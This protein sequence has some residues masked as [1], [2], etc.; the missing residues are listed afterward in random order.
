EVTAWTLHHDRIF[1]VSNTG[2]AFALDTETGE[3][4]WI[5]QVGK[6]GYRAF[7]PGA[8]SK[9][10]AI[11]SG[12]KI[13]VLDRD[14]G[15]ILFS[16][17]LGS[18]PGAGPA[19]TEDY[20]FV[21]LMT[22]RVEGYR[23]D[24]PKAQPWYYN[25]R[26]RAF[27]RPVTTGGVVSWPTNAGLLYVSSATDP[28]LLYRIQTNDEIIAPP[29]ELDGNL[30]IASLDGYLY[31]IDGLTGNE[32]WRFAAG[33]P[34]ESQPAVVGDMAFVSSIE[35]AIHAIETSTGNELWDIPGASQFVSE[36]K[37]RVYAA[38]PMGNLL[39]LDM[40][41]G[42]TLGTL[43]T[44]EG[45]YPL[46]NDQTDRIFLVNKHGLVQCLHEIGVSQPIEHR[47]MKTAAPK[48]KDEG[49]EDIFGV[50]EDAADDEPAEGGGLFD[51]AVEEP[52][53]QP[54][55]EDEPEDEPATEPQGDLFD[56]IDL[57]E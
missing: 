26:G 39:V 19:L 27:L 50:N 14:D 31:S 23:L 24:D 54:A 8:N 7:G 22:G 56:D 41:T 47:K 46:V 15:R 55:V 49:D 6:R 36:G 17:D 53:D 44:A 9:S 42:A 43:A 18:A 16:R 3:R 25:S 35:P 1:G 20:A 11:V 38:D 40:K 28:G 34:I 5:R 33:W 13:Y 29:A 12:S 52:D 2:T 4:L 48:K 57:F 51:D 32:Q 10:V 45:L 37:N 21:V 30:F